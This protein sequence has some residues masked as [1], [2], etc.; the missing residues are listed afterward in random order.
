MVGGW[1]GDFG[2]AHIC[3]WLIGIALIDAVHGGKARK[4][5]EAEAIDPDPNADVQEDAGQGEAEHPVPVLLLL[6]LL[7]FEEILGEGGTVNRYVC[8][9]GA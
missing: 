7:V 5:T 6:L 1:V 4:R 2:L 9:D 3:T 8:V